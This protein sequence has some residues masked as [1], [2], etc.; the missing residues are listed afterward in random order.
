MNNK[1][2]NNINYEA[3]NGVKM[4]K[5]DKAMLDL[6]CEDIKNEPARWQWFYGSR[7]HKLK[8]GISGGYFDELNK[9]EKKNKIIILLPITLEQCEEWARS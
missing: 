1:F 8:S 7:K 9:I 3:I 5:K 6:I 4:T 2:L